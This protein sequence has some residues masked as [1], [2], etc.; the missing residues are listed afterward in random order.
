MLDLL[1]GKEKRDIVT[2]HHKLFIYKT[3]ERE[4]PRVPLS[5]GSTL[6]RLAGFFR[7]IK[8]TTDTCEKK[9]A[10]RSSFHLIIKTSSDEIIRAPSIAAA[11]FIELLQLE[12][13]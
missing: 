13:S 7:F 2:L 1:D 3:S 12:G 9:F 11:A 4:Y 8:D 6:R 5:A 10:C